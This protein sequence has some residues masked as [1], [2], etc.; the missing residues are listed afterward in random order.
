[1]KKRNFC[2]ERKDH[3]PVKQYFITTTNNMYAQNS[4]GEPIKFNVGDVICCN[5]DAKC[6]HLPKDNWYMA[7]MPTMQFCNKEYEET[8]K[9]AFPLLDCERCKAHFK[10]CIYAMMKVDPAA[11][12]NLPYKKSSIKK[13]MVEIENDELKAIEQ[14][15]ALKA[16]A[17]ITAD[18]IR[19]Y[20]KFPIITRDFINAVF[21]I[22]RK[23]GVKCSKKH[24][25]YLFTSEDYKQDLMSYD[26]YEILSIMR[27]IDSDEFG[28]SLYK[29]FQAAF[30]DFLSAEF[31]KW[32]TAF[33]FEDC[34]A[35]AYVEVLEE[36]KDQ[37]T[38]D[39]LNNICTLEEWQNLLMS[40]ARNE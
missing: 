6:P 28:N 38:D 7:Y 24:I 1:M 16:N 36:L 31:A 20:I 11:I 21:D 13:L 23:I 39:I 15:E 3:R 40:L 19:P 30:D 35:N 29:E 32:N 17:E 33:A 14:I 5:V 4:E 12:K 26:V 22:V 18:Q 27:D 10:K 25:E 37:I 34:F 2:W 8:K 9:N